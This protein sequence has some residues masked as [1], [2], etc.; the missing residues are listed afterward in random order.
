MANKSSK[1]K[2]KP[3]VLFFEPGVKVTKHIYIG[4]RVLTGPFIPRALKISRIAK[5]LGK[6]VIWGGPHP[7]ILPEQTLKHPFIDAVV[8]GEG[9][10]ALIDLIDY[11]QGKKIKPLGCGV[12]EKEKLKFH[13]PQKKCVDLEKAPL[14]AWDLLENIDEHFPSKKGNPLKVM[15]SRGC[16]FHCAFC[17]NSN[18]NVRK[19]LGGYRVIS[20]KKVLDEYELVQSLIKNKITML[21][22]GGDYH[23]VSKE[24]TR[25]W[26][27]TLKKRAPHLKWSTCGRFANL[28]HEMIKMIADA[29]CVDINLG[30]ES[31]SKRIQDLNKKPV[32]LKKSIPLAKH[33]RKRKIFLTNTYIFGHPTETFRELKQTIRYLRKLPAD[34]NLIQVYRPFPGTPYYALCQQEKK[35]IPFNRLEEWSTFGTMIDD[36]NMSR[37]P[38]GALFFYFYTINFYEQLKE[39]FNRQIYYLRNGFYREF[40][41]NFIAN[42]FVKKLKEI[43]ENYG[44]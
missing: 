20:A 38:S 25:N 9:E 11:F 14:P 13:A 15:A 10:Y 32:D 27:E 19:Y 33:L 34:L 12:K 6:K 43:L 39:L 22:A 23:L 44:I 37:V 35:V 17:H 3:K 41:N 24:Y 36:V 2:P 28:D 21:D 26:C 7:T 1:S 18:E 31:G 5:K 4:I 8:V 30:V 42:R 16:A 29:N 40:W